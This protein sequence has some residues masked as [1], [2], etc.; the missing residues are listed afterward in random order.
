MKRVIIHILFLSLCFATKAQVGC[1]QNMKQSE[2]LFIAGEYDNCIQV[3]EKSLKECGFSKKKKEFMLELLAKAHL[4]LDNLTQADKAVYSLLRN[5]PHYELKEN[6]DHE[7][8]EILVKKFDAH[9]LLSLGVRNTAMRPVFKSTRTYTILD[10][11]DYDAPY[12]TNQTVL[13]YYVI[14]EYEFTKGYSLNVDV[15]NYRLSY[16]RNLAKDQGPALVYLENLRFVEVPL[17]LKKYLSFGK[18]F[19]TYA[20]LGVGYLRT[21]EAIGTAGISYSNEDVYSGAKTDF[22][23]SAT[24]DMLPQRMKNSYEWLGGIGVGF[25]FRG[26]GIFLDAR[27]TGGL[28]SLTN[29]AKRYYNPELVNNY[30]YVDNTVKINKYEVGI[31]LSYTLKNVIKK[32]R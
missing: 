2:E 10:N 28:S 11:V 17:Y 23:S 18:N 3:L 13:L 7:D 26:L 1:D 19:T 31:S 15:I 14:G 9:P 25:K 16:S 6:T 29:P 20:S 24:S 5:N 30:F 12:T 22:S 4:E 32:V 21:L 27:Y 8:F